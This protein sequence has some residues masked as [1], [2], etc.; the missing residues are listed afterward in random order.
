VSIQNTGNSTDSYIIIA[1]L[2]M[3]VKNREGRYNRFQEA[4][5]RLLS[6]GRDYVCL[7]KPE[8]YFIQH[9]RAEFTDFLNNVTRRMDP[10]LNR[11]ALYFA[12]EAYRAERVFASHTGHGQVRNTAATAA[13][14]N[15]VMHPVG[16]SSGRIGLTV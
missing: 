6:G 3:E 5:K 15:P 9:V 10:G 16:H 8:T 4:E 13:F 11:L 14:Y 7:I 2:N 1:F 12:L